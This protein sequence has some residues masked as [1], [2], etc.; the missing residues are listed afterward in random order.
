MAIIAALVGFGI[1]LVTV[2]FGNKIENWILRWLAALG[3]I[4][5]G[6][7]AAGI[8]AGD[9]HQAELAGQILGVLI[10][11]FFII[12]VLFFRKAKAEK[13]KKKKGSPIKT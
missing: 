8:I 5:L 6:G 11:V 9:V 7:I 3:G 4:L 13:T 2:H 1:L 12:K 10:I